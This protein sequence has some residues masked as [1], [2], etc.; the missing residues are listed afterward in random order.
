VLDFLLNL[1][2]YNDNTRNS[3][4]DNYYR[5]A[6]VTAL[7]NCRVKETTEVRSTMPVD[8]NLDP[9][10]SSF[11]SES[12][13]RACRLGSGWI[14]ILCNRTVQNIENHDTFDADK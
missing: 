12:A 9:F 1:F 14:R 10:G 5:A 7:G 2:K 3:F 8:P 4:S 6:L 11:G 13:S